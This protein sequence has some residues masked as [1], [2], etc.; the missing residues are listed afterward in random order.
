MLNICPA[1]GGKCWVNF[2]HRTTPFLPPN[3]S[4][5]TTGRSSTK[6]TYQT[7]PPYL[8]RTI[9]HRSRRRRPPVQLRL[10]TSTEPNLTSHHYRSRPPPTG[11]V[12]HRMKHLQPL[13]D[14]PPSPTTGPSYVLTTGPSY[15]LTTE[16]TCHQG[17]TEPKHCQARAWQPRPTSCYVPPRPLPLASLYK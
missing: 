3:H 16:P 11:P 14:Q 5:P 10:H 8:Y 17:P 1:L 2:L 13:P 9:P 4:S 6:S 12:H 7:P 15:V